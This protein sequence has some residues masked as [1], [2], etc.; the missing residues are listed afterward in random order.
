MRT[1]I[2]VGFSLLLGPAIAGGQANDTTTLATVIVSATKA[3]AD[4]ASLTQP[5]T[6]LTGKELR[7]R[8]IVRV[9][10][11]LRTVPGATVAQNG[12]TGSVST[13]F[14]RGGESR[15]T[16]VLIDGV[17]VNAPGGFFDFSHLSTDNIERIEIV[18]G[19]AGVVHGADAMSGI[20]QV[21]T[22]QGRGPVAGTGQLRA[23]SR[24]AR[25]A[26]LEAG[27]SSGRGRYSFGGGAQRTDGVHS[28]NNQYYNGSLSASA[29]FSPRP[30]TDIQVSSR[31]SAAEFHYPTDYT[32]QPVDSNSY[33]VQHRLTT[34]ISA[35]TRLTPGLDARLSIGSN[36]VSDLTE[37][38]AL[39]F[40]ATD[41]VNAALLS[42]NKRRS[43]ELG[44]SAVVP[45]LGTLSAGGEFM[46]ERE[47]SVNEE[48]P[49]GGASVPTTSFSASRNN[50]AVYA[51]LTG[52]LVS[53]VGY[54][55]ATRLDDNSD[56]DAHVTYRLGASA[57]VTAAT[58]L[59][60]S[61]S[62]AFNAPAFNQIHPTLYT[63]ASPGLDPE[64][65]VSW[66]VGAEQS[67]ARGAI[68]LSAGY[69]RQRFED[70]IQYVN[71]SPPDFLGSFANLTEAESNGFEVEARI[72]PSGEWSGWASYSN[73]RPRVKRVSSGYEGDLRPGDALLRRPRH[74]GGASVAWSRA[75]TGSVS[76]TAAYAG[77]RPD[78]DF[79]QFPSPLVTLPSYVTFDVAGS[80]EV[81][82]TASGRSS[83]AI[84]GRVENLFDRRY[85]HVLNFAVPGRTILLGA[86]YSGA[87]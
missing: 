46:N 62:T 85:E 16:K 25:E 82:V 49:V 38:I 48:G 74:S 45:G 17:A 67:V 68:T 66:E 36:E 50:R 61:L 8:G 40:G 14:L 3:P 79:S 72:A 76:A 2:A 65:G 75:G 34:G 56:Y 4:R 63:K 42:R 83:L 43:A 35:A 18:R 39:P 41:P 57:P 28:F 12:S 5:V 58:R 19:P 73:S 15:Y 33:R 55:V 77:E 6:V 47:R 13:L 23:G 86:R 87:L 29:G 20:I 64:R 1:R 80:K 10:D 60:A 7:D 84:T 51:E 78:M 37:D 44:V 27:G 22:R 70:M 69:F 81:F 11:A 52:S 54:T 21:F 71:G 31:Y 9:S 59:R 53:R 30:G 24:G 26:S 32:G